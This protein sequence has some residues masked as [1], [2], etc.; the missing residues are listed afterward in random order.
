MNW[1]LPF[2]ATFCSIKEKHFLI[3]GRLLLYKMSQWCL[4]SCVRQPIRSCR[5]KR[6]N[7]FPV[8]KRCDK[9]HFTNWDRLQNPTEDTNLSQQRGLLNVS[10]FLRLPDF[11]SDLWHF[12]TRKLPVSQVIA[13]SSAAFRLTAF[14]LPPAGGA[15]I[16]WGWS[17]LKLW[18]QKTSVTA[19]TC[20]EAWQPS[21]RLIRKKEILCPVETPEPNLLL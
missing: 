7:R 1:F 15:V 14:L 6:R 21:P 12:L 3:D 2:K 18:R 17:A 8:K 11:K 16:S 13:A 5:R 10:P 19:R 4:V 20:A 9:L